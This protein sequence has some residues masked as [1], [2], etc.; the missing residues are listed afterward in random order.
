MDY[1]DFYKAI[2]YRLTGFSDLTIDALLYLFNEIEYLKKN[3]Q[4]KD[5][6]F[7]PKAGMYFE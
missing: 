6:N 2:G 1:N 4:V 5:T 7:T 3:E